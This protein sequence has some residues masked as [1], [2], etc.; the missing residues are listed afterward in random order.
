LLHVEPGQYTLRVSRI[1]YIEQLVDIDVGL[2]PQLGLDF[3]LA[4]LAQ[5]LQGVRVVGRVRTGDSGGAPSNEWDDEVGAWSATRRDLRTRSSLV[6]ADVLL[7]TSVA[8]GI[9]SAPE[10]PTSLHVRGGAGDQNVVL[11]DGIPLYNATHFGGVLS[12]VNPDVVSGATMHTGVPSAR[13]GDVLS[14]VIELH[15]DEKAPARATFRGAVDASTTRQG[16]IGR[17]LGGRGSFALAGRV[18]SRELLGSFERRTSSVTTFGDVFGRV[19]LPLRGGVLEALSI[20]SSDRLVF[21]AV[22]SGDKPSGIAEMPAG[23]DGARNRFDWSS[24]AFGLVWDGNVRP[25]TAL[26]VRLWRTAFDGHADWAA[27]ARPLAMQS[28][29]QEYGMSADVERRA[30]GGFVA[31]GVRYLDRGTSYHVASA[32][33]SLGDSVPTTFGV[34]GRSPL[35]ALYVERRALGGTRW[36]LLSGIRAEF[37]VGRMPAIDPRISLRFTASDRLTLLAGYGRTHQFTQSLGNDES[38]VD[39]LIGVVL[40]AM[41]NGTDRPVA[42]ADQLSIGA[43]VSIGAASRLSVESYARRLG[44]LLLVAPGSVDPFARSIV[45]SGAGR[46]IGASAWFEH[47]GARA[48]LLAGYAFGVTDRRVG[49]VRYVPTFGVQHAVA[50]SL[51]LHLDQRTALQLVFRADGGRRGRTHAGVVEWPIGTILSEVTDLSGSPVL[52]ADAVGGSPLAAYARTDVAVQHEWPVAAAR[53][54]GHVTGSL[55]VENIFARS[56]VLGVYVPPGGG[57]R[58]VLPMSPRALRIGLSWEL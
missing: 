6:G 19:T 57:P 31:G 30:G 4:P 49:G 11:L 32:G 16:V 1:G 22:A 38:L 50:A 33:A 18:V 47:T 9:A 39:A 13:F 58:R 20:G 35:L 54:R 46:A 21:D 41:A 53:L 40:P 43:R 34:A 56:N 5:P 14:S 25:S 23:T 2:D 15:T 51:A 27:S 45:P 28:G 10:A 3:S 55:R 24:H 48:S 12:A 37:G 44:C 52:S 26:R 7:A 29:L 17:L 36:S 42:V 8:G